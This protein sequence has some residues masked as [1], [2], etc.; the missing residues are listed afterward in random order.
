[1]LLVLRKIRPGTG[2]Y[3]VSKP[4]IF[5]AISGFVSENSCH[6]INNG[7]YFTPIT[8]LCLSQDYNEDSDDEN[9]M[10]Y[11]DGTIKLECEGTKVIFEYNLCF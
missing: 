11:K 5:K 10:W 4:N 9:N 2:F 6:F 7:S 8:P 1:M 3:F